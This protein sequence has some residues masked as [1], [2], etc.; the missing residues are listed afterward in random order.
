MNVSKSKQR[1]ENNKFVDPNSVN[2]S[3]CICLGLRRC[4]LN[5][6]PTNEGKFTLVVRNLNHEDQTFIE[7]FAL[8][9]VQN[10]KKKKRES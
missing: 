5:P 9:V 3:I 8:A 1:K 6:S 10:L 4:I 7:I 2:H